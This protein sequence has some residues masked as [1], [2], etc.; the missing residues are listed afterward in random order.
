MNLIAKQDMQSGRYTK[1]DIVYGVPANW[2]SQSALKCVHDMIDYDTD[3]KIISH[4][5]AMDTEEINYMSFK[6]IA[7]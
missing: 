6:E 1:T 4:V 5:L 2:E 3:R 7:D